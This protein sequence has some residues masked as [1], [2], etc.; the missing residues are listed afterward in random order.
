MNS[1]EQANINLFIYLQRNKILR[2]TDKNTENAYTKT[3]KNVCVVNTSFTY[4]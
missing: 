1:Y 4:L 3:G 2:R